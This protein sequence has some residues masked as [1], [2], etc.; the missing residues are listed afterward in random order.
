MELQEVLSEIKLELTGNV[1]ELELES[2]DLIQI[3]HKALREIGRY[4]DETTYITV[5]FASCIDITNFN[6]SA[7]VNVFRTTAF[8]DTTSEKNVM[9]DPL[10]A[11]QW[12]LFSNGGSMYNLQDYLMNYASWSTLQQIKNTL[13]TDL[14]FVEDKHNNKL[15]INKGSNGSNRITIE[16]IP[17]LTDVNEIKS[18]YWIDKLIRMSVA[19]TKQIIGRIRT[20]YSQSNAIWTQDGDKLLEEGN[21]EYKEL[22]ELLRSND[23]VIYPIN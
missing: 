2:A 7:I 10:Y 5:P 4:W 22:H 6:S 1:L 14:S 8:G 23:N 11:Q 19:I 20:R 9:S 13:S 12:M 18:D 17:K 15:Y 16:Y 3:V 21:T